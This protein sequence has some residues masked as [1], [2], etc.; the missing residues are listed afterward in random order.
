MDSQHQLAAQFAPVA[1]Q[2]DPRAR[3][4]GVR[5]LTGGMS[6]QITVLDLVRPDAPQQTVVVRQYGPKNV[7]ADSRPAATETRLLALL[8][9]AG[10]PV[11]EP[12][13]ADDTRRLLDRPYAVISYVAGQGPAATW[14]DALA[15]QLVNVLVRLH[16]LDATPVRDWL[17][18]YAARVDRWLARTPGR[19]DESMRES[20]I[21]AELNRWWPQRTEL[22]G[23][24]LHGDYW[25]GN[26]MWSEGRLVAVID[27]EDAAWGDQ[28]S[29]LANIRLELLWAYG[30]EASRDFT[31][32]YRAAFPTVD[33][34]DQP[35]W[36]LVAAT[37]PV[38]RLDEWGLDPA[39][40]ETFLRQYQEFVDAALIQVG[41]GAP[42]T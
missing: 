41:S 35:Y 5:R 33:F 26:T 21:R 10:I 17:R 32:R 13:L 19:P 23:R 12:R 37:R 25:P 30:Y 6:A 22:P 4:G 34:G 40:M 14:S 31:D 24:I 16:R 20:R 7:T 18:P 3:V 15:E 27:W 2:L 8:R 39:G 38:G 36:D 9:T 11:P 29:D 28:R 42:D 1:R